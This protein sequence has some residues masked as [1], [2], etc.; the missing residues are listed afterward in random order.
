[1]PKAHWGTYTPLKARLRKEEL[2]MMTNPGFPREAGAREM[3]AKDMVMGRLNIMRELWRRGEAAEQKEADKELR[4]MVSRMKRERVQERIPETKT[5]ER[6]SAALKKA[7]AN[8]RHAIEIVRSL[9]HEK[10]KIA[11]WEASGFI[12]KYRE[13]IENLKDELAKVEKDIRKRQG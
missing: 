1:M 11:E 9:Q 12:K 3:Y 5:L 13:D 4:L 8:D 10:S 7:I 6:Y 2:A